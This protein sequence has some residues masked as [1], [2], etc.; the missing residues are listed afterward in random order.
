MGAN[1]TES[2]GERH[3]CALNENV[4]PLSLESAGIV[5]NMAAVCL[6]P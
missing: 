1:Y 5:Y 4:Q 3:L 2:W 6:A